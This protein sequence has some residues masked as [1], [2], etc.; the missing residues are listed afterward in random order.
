MRAWVATAARRPRLGG[1]DGDAGGWLL[2]PPATSGGHP[3]RHSRVSAGGSGTLDDHAGAS[4]SW[5]TSHLEHPLPPLSIQCYLTHLYLFTPTNSL[6][7][8]HSRTLP[9]TLTHTHTHRGRRAR[10]LMGRPLALAQRLP[11]H[12]ALPVPHQLC[13]SLSCPIVAAAGAT[14][15]EYGLFPYKP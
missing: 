10:Q 5:P 15:W 11:S 3:T 14:T 12:L 6:T 9:R 4:S 13:R 7:H 2:L 8:S 1:Y